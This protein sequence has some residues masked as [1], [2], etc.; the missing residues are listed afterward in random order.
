M[1]RWG[2]TG[3]AT[4]VRGGR[5]GGRGIEAAGGGARLRR[6]ARRRERFQGGLGRVGRS[7]DRKSVV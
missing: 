4:R 3:T 2:R 5:V 1:R 6:A 7:L